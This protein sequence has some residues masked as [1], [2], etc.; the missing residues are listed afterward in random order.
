MFVR[1]DTGGNAAREGAKLWFLPTSSSMRFR[2]FL[3]VRSGALFDGR[4]ARCGV[5]PVHG[6][7]A[8]RSDNDQ[9]PSG[10]FCRPC[11]ATGDRWLRLEF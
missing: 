2:M 1:F 5:E 8:A 11:E 10:A 4:A 7:H 3:T 6:S 9:V